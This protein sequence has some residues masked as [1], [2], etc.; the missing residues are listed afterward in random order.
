MLNQQT[1]HKLYELKLNGMAEAL[2]DQLNQPDMDRLSFTERFSLIVDRQWT[3][4]EN[5]RLERYLKN[6]RMKLNACVEDIDYKTPRGIDQSVVMHLISCDWVR[7]HHNIIVTGPTGS[8]KTFLACALTNKA[9]REGFRALY[10]RAPKFS[11][12]MALAK[13]DGSYGKTMAKLAKAHVLVIDDLGLMPMSDAE[14]RDL[15]EVVEDRHGRASTI[16]ASQLPIDH[17]HEQIGDPTIADAIL[18][19]LVHNA[20]KINLS[21]KG[22]SMRKKY[23]ALT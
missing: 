22:E 11:Y 23:G 3:W 18:D 9:C 12:Q 20:H 4:K 5:N 16:I 15:L 8:G 21:M 13:G 7:R 6:A 19:R 10:L 1:I 2:A 14:R 17:W